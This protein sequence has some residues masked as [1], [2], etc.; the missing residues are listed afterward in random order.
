MDEFLN[1]LKS[2]GGSSDEDSGGGFDFSMFDFT[3]D[4]NTEESVF[5]PTFGGSMPLPPE[6][7]EGSFDISDPAF[8]P[9]SEDNPFG[10]DPGESYN[11]PLPSVGAKD[12][13]DL[14]KKGGSQALDY[15]K[16]NPG[17]VGLMAALTALGAMDKRPAYGGGT[18]KRYTGPAQQLTRTVTQGKY[19]PIANFRQGPAVVTPEQ[20][21][22]FTPAVLDAL[23]GATRDRE[24]SEQRRA[25]TVTP[26][27]EAQWH[28]NDY[29]AGGGETHWS[30]VG[31]VPTPRVPD[32]RETYAAEGGV[33][34]AY[35]NGGKVAPV[36]M[37]D[38]GFVMTK[39]AV[40]GA[41][42]PQGIQ[43][44]VPQARMIRGPGHGTSDSIPAYIQGPNGRT[45]ARVS[46]GEAYVPPQGDNPTERAQKTR[47][48]Y[49]LMKS[50]ERRA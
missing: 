8:Y 29:A 6:M 28:T 12:F 50:L 42:G 35:A 49:A 16:N 21:M 23:S 7:P 14:L 3:P 38:G 32:S 48:L 2:F 18:T 22:L 30:Q 31:R 47:Q 33:M 34:H 20:D 39:R 45:P 9:R 26:E 37:Q 43:S 25:G 41:G 24:R 15:L 17:K 4:S 36:P 19:G 46:N 10:Y 40:D 44:L 13:L 27:Q 11:Q 1:W 5:D